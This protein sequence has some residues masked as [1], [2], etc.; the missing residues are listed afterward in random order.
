M[1]R[2]SASLTS[3]GYDV[4]GSLFAFLPALDSTPESWMIAVTVGIGILCMMLLTPLVIRLAKQ[5][6]WVAFPQEDR[7]HDRPVALMGGIAIFGSSVVA[8]TLSGAYEFYSWPVWLAGGLVFFA[9]LADDLYDI[10]PEAKLVV[11][12]LA[13]VL[14][15]YAGFAF[16]RGGPFWLSVPLTFLWVI[17]VT[18]AVNLIDGMD[19]LAAGLAAIA[20]SIIGLVAWMIGITQVAVV[21]GAVAGAAA[22]FLIFNFQPARIFMGD[23]GSMFLGFTLAT[24]ALT[25][26]GKGGPFAATLVPIVVLA[27]PIFDTTF[28]TITRILNGVPVTQGGTDHT[29]HRLVTLGLS[30]RRTV[31]LLYTVSAIF[32]LSTLAV[33]QSTASLFYALALLAIVGLVGFGMYLW[34]AHPKTTGQPEPVFT[35]R[36]G[37]VMRAMFGGAGWKSFVGT[38]AD[39]L[40]VAATFIAAHHLRF[41][42]TPPGDVYEV[43]LTALPA[44]IGLKIAIFY[45][46]NLYH[47]IW[48]HAG[49]PELVRLVGASTLASLITYLGLIIAFGANTIAPAVVVI[50]WM[51]TTGAIGLLRFGFRGLRQYFAS[52]RTEGPRAVIY[53]NDP[54]ALLAVR[55][56]RQ[57]DTEI[58]RTIV[59]FLSDEPD[60]QG[61]HTQGLSI[62]GTLDHLP[63]TCTQYDIDEVIVTA[64]NLSS[65]EKEIIQRECIAHGVTCR[66][67][68]V[69]LDPHPESGNAS[70]S[71]GDGASRTDLPHMSS[72]S[73]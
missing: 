64:P 63:E 10:R 50:D 18:N 30:E 31:L 15:L 47:G 49:T 9:G 23:C 72:R 4:T 12:I 37:A 70:L 68:S 3:M 32:G 17:G 24:L 5:L 71:S 60:Q 66:Y 14:L 36:F 57:P 45:I 19:G 33:Y 1:E 67:F 48:R 62:L 52:H 27:V 59:G 69:S 56:F 29:M 35:Q 65:E 46:A 13:T 54:T 34:S 26:Q 28:V 73:S 8:V 53:G 39:L 16:W 42:A 40:L 25:V 7:W 43:M 20:A 22:G 41:G 2:A 51:L 44:V 6:G 38:V 21:A 55:Y 61:L 58:D 11:Q